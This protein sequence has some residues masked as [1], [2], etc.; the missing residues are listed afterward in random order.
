LTTSDDAPALGGVYKLVEIAGPNG[1]RQV[2]KR[3]AGKRTQPGAKQVWRIIED[4][5]ASR[6]IVSLIGELP[7]V[8]GTPLLQRVMRSG[9]RLAKPAALPGLRSRC[10][11][12]IAVMPGWMTGVEPN[13]DYAVE[14]ST[15]LQAYAPDAASAR[16]PMTSASIAPAP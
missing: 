6:D 15:G 10:A 14:F 1:V 5:V 2:L 8:G 7:P 4:G 9:V 12:L 11:E 13:V 16:P 3:S